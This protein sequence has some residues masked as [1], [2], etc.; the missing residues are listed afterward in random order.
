VVTRVGQPEGF[1]VAIIPP[2]S[3][4]SSDSTDRYIEGA[5]SVS[6]AFGTT[7]EGLEGVS[8]GDKRRVLVFFPTYNEAGNVERLVRTIR[9]V[10]PTASLIVV[11]DASP[12]GTG[13]IL[14]RLAA[15]VGDFTVVHRP[16]KLG[17]GTAH[18]IAMIHARDQ[19]FDALVTMDADFSHHPKYL[20]T[21]LELLRRADFVTGSR[22]LNGGQSDY[23]F[24]RA[25]ISRTANFFAK[26]ALGLPL[27]ENTTM[28]R[29]FTLDL[30]KR[31]DIDAI[32]SEG[33]SF[34]VESLH[35]VS[36]V[37]RKLAEFP[38][39]FENRA[40]GVSKISQAEI[41]KA[42]V[43]IQRLGVARLFPKK[44][45]GEAPID[46]VTCNGCGGTHHGELYPAKE[47]E[48]APRASDLSP[49]SCATHTSRT[50]GQ[51]L[52]C[53]HC[54]LVFM[55]PKLTPSALVGEYASAVD[56]VYLEHIAARET[57]FRWNLRQ[58]RHF[59]GPRDRML[60]IGSYCGAFLRVARE[61]GIDVVGVEPSA[62]AVQA[63][64]QV[65][66]APVVCGTVDDLPAERRSFDVV[67]AWDVLEHFADPKGEMKK[68]HGLLRDDGMFLFS[69]LMIDNWFP[70]ALGQHWP[71]LM[72][73]HLFYFTEQ[74][75]RQLLN[76]TGFELVDE[77]KY[78]HV[79]TLPYLLS[80]LGTLGV[81]LAEPLSRAVSKIGGERAQ[82]PFR[83]GDIKL[84]V[85]RKKGEGA[86][87][88]KTRPSPSQAFHAAPAAE[89]Q[90]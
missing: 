8:S 82:I 45:K 36:R 23:G 69:T 18:K 72:D 81:P 73:M 35:Q 14:D 57:T 55:R 30:L 9:E 32:R 28:Y 54:G 46:I 48:D 41:Y 4:Q 59:I 61:E 76:D 88:S 10:L 44:P 66:D 22:Y 67:A 89:A 25:I 80:K 12:D 26:A 13:E 62:W 56:P 16:G 53:L 11:D 68:I 90:G 65:T 75:I 49:Y 77:G 34:A 7:A 51:I 17:L 85:C 87:R 52:K 37:T 19:G 47:A 50:H 86:A 24:G 6:G 21:M 70:K 74:T 31:L 58:V 84:F 29:G 42:V 79:V 5:G 33:Y 39:H 71:W 3:R 38:I 27:E 78:T 83:F 2:V 60:E 15:E 40:Q 43:T 20:P 63:S 64:K 1:R